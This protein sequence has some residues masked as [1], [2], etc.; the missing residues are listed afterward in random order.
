MERS[1]RQ[2]KARAHARGEG[3][4]LMMVNFAEA[5][6]YNGAGR[7]HEALA[8]AREEL[9]YSHELGHAMRVPLQVVKAASRTGER[10]VAVEAVERLAA[11]TRPVRD[12]DW[13]LAFL[14]VAQAQLRQGAEAE[15]LYQ[16]AIT[17]FGR[18]RIPMLKAP[19]QL[20]YG[21]MLG[22]ENRRVDARVQLRAA[23]DAL[24]ASGMKGLAERAPVS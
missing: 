12:C 1:A 14:A 17:R 19:S 23:Y 11:V 15:T 8:S 16:E 10:A 18:V 9:P 6:V 22:R 20:L 21:E 4:A 24:S 3:Y 7:Y 13:A 5:V 2:V